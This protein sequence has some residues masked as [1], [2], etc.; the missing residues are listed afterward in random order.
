MK[1]TLILILFSTLSFAQISM[2][3]CTILP[4]TDSVDGAISYKV[5]SEIEAFLKDSEWCEYKSNSILINIFD[6]YRNNLKSHLKNPKVVKLVS[7]RLNVGTIIRVNL[8]S[9][10]K[11]MMVELEIV[12]D[13]G[14]D[15]FLSEKTKLSSNSIELISRTIKNWINL[16]EKNIPYDGK[17]SGILGDQLTINIGRDN[18]VKVGNDFIIKRPI[19]KRRHPLLKQVVEWETQILARGKIFSISDK[20]AL[21]MVKV[22]TKDKK[23]NIGDWVNIDRKSGNFA[24]K[25]KYPDIKKNEF[26]KLGLLTVTVDLDSSK[27]ITSVSNTSKEAAGFILGFDLIAEVWF[28]RKYFG[29]IEVARRFG[30]LSA[31]VGSFTKSDVGL[32]SGKMKFLAG[33][34]YLPMG[35][36]YGPQI[37]VY[38]GLSKYTYSPDKSS[39][40]G[41]GE[42]EFSGITLG[43]KASIPMH[44]LIRLLLKVEMLLFVDYEDV[45]NVTG[46]SSGESTLEIELGARYAFSPLFSIDFYIERLSSKATF[47]GAVSEINYQDTVFKAG[48][49]LKF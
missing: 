20:Q 25:I 6:K 44:K 45:S 30:T 42:N 29:M 12:G 15:I 11:G 33:Y 17:V 35:Y 1:L 8:T 19:R 26:G 28:T 34:K 9:E 16:F 49:T 2:R 48:A 13:N 24:S 5:F 27:V 40:D 7:Q 31:E 4:I 21:A 18:K 47:G 41:L 39:S 3:K 32:T 36:F 22:Y 38:T 10:I 43:V 14:E 23:L 46:Y 37:D